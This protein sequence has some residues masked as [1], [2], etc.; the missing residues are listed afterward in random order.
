MPSSYLRDAA[1]KREKGGEE[2]Q[3]SRCSAAEACP[4]PIPAERDGLRFHAEYRSVEVVA[5]A[6]EDAE[7]VILHF[8]FL[9]IE[10]DVIGGNEVAAVHGKG[11]V[12]ANEVLHAA[13]GRKD[14]GVSVDV[15]V[16]GFGVG[17][18]NAGAQ[19]R[20]KG[21]IKD[22]VVLGTDSQFGAHVAI[23]VA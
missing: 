14:G 9:T 20:H 7:F 11:N 6:E 5:N 22:E 13:A 8:I 15:A 4:Q 18:D 1:G 21:R 12:V 17:P 2:R 10:E 23:A 16:I 19:E 3:S